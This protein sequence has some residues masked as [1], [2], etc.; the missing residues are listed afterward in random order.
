[1]EVDKKKLERYIAKHCSLAEFSAYNDELR[2][3]QKMQKQCREFGLSVE[4]PND[5]PHLNSSV[6]RCIEGKCKYVR[7]TI[8]SL[9]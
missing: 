8:K 9:I 7:N 4:C 3:Y 1:M 5:C 2:C 6:V